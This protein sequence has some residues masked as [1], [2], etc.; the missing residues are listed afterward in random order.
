MP[1]KTF[2]NKFTLLFFHPYLLKFPAHL[3]T[4]KTLLMPR[5]L[6]GLLLLVIN[7]TTLAQTRQLNGT[8]SEAGSI[9]AT[10]KVKDKPI[11]DAD[12]RFSFRIPEPANLGYMANASAQNAYVINDAPYYKRANIA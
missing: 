6:V 4:H 3:L 5:N 10:I 8:V 2:R 7:L 11:T 9:S 12:G 1:G